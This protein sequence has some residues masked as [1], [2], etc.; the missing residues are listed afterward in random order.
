MTRDE[1]LASLKALV[2]QAERDAIESTNSFPV[3]D[4]CLNSLHAQSA[5]RLRRAESSYLLPHSLQSGVPAAFASAAE[6]HLTLERTGS[7]DLACIVPPGRMIVL[8][9][10][11][12]MYTNSE[13]IEYARRDES[14]VR[15]VTFVCTV[16]GEIGNLDFL[17]NDDVTVPAGETTGYFREE[18]VTL[19]DQSRGRTGINASILVYEGATTIKDSGVPA[20][21]ENT[22]ADLYAEI[23]YSTTPAIIGKR[24]RIKAHR[25]PGIEEPPDSNIRPT[26]AILDD[27]HVPEIL[28]GAWLDDG[29]V[30]TDYQTEAGDQAE[31]DFPLLPAAPAVG[32]AFYWGAVDPITALSLRIDTAAVGVFELAWETW[33]GVAWTTPTTIADGSIGLT[34]SGTV[35]IELGLADLQAAVA[36]NGVLAYWVRVRVTAFTSLATQPLGSYTAPLCYKPLT[37]EAETIE[38]GVLDWKDMGFVITAARH[39]AL[40]RDDDLGMLGDNRGMY[41]GDGESEDAFRSRISK[42]PDVVSPNALT[43]V[44]NRILA[45][46]RL[47]GRVVDIGDEVHGFF[48]DVDALDYYQPGDTYPTNQWKL[49]LSLWEA[50]G[51]FYVQVP[52]VSDGDFGMAYDEGPT[53]Y[54]ADKGLYLGPAYDEGFYDGFSPVAS[55]QIYDLIYKEIRARK[56]GGIDFAILPDPTLN[57][58]P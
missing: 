28:R 21:F 44:V 38:W 39:G 19:A 3:Y 46:L 10:S 27:T 5:R 11:G 35:R 55:A 42:V 34:A 14:A 25:W 24:Y 29:G 53:L 13:A 16:K 22:D 33:N 15:E 31:G 12:R 51:F 43:R 41:P 58:L 26:Y 57:T 8:G 23:L 4:A 48:L 32:D 47:T 37:P 56:G 30:F 40:G 1:L 2:P 9:P 17:C 20:T 45:P 54:L 52:L 49:L 6:L 7:L 36:V 50:H 18:H